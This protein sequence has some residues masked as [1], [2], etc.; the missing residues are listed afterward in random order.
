M[1]T[2]NVRVNGSLAE[3]LGA[4]RLSVTL[5][6]EPTLQDLVSELGARYPDCVELIERAVAVAGGKHLP[7]TAALVQGQ[8]VALL[9]P[10]AGG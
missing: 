1:T 5:P 4:S 6:E 10:I 3:A 9:M 2:V 7:S 8:E